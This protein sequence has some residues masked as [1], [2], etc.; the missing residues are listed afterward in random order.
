MSGLASLVVRASSQ[1][2]FYRYHASFAVGHSRG[3]LVFRAAA[4]ERSAL[5]YAVGLIG[6]GC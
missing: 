4:L 6:R 2:K 1:A 5:L 3:E